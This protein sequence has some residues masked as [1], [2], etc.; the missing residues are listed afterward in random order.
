MIDKPV[1]EGTSFT[2]FWELDRESLSRLSFLGRVEWLQ[3]RTH[4]TLLDPL[5]MLEQQNGSAFVWLAVTELVCAGIEALGGFHGGKK[6]GSHSSFCNFVNSFMRSDFKREAPDLSGQPRTYCWHLQEYF[7]NG[8]DDTLGV[9]YGMLWLS[10]E[11]DL[12]GYLRPDPG[13]VGIAVCPQMLL[14]DFR[15][16]VDSYFAKLSR[17]GPESL[18][19]INFHRGFERVRKQDP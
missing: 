19:G 8:L 6:N 4:K 18:I 16:A 12:E 11:S 17:E 2:L 5:A 9:R 7:R 15:H 13:G 3:L 14:D 10:T 1:I